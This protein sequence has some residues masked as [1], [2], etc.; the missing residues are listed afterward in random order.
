MEKR[1][2]G[3]TH[4]LRIRI[5]LFVVYD[6]II[7]VRS[8]EKIICNCFRDVHLRSHRLM[9]SLATGSATASGL[10]RPE[11]GH[12][13]LWFEA[14]VAVADLLFYYTGACRNLGSA[15]DEAMSGLRKRLSMR[16]SM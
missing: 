6:P 16:L 15:V 7:I 8:R 3:K 10:A 1:E 2:L 12:E 11:H 9:T 5:G 14:S 4:A 13:P